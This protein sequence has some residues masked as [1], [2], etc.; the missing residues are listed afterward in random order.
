LN[1][2]ESAILAGL[3]QSPTYY[4][5]FIG[6]NDA[7]R[8]RAQDVL[9]RMREDGYITGDQEKA[10]LKQLGQIKFSSPKIS[11]LAPHFVFYVKDQIENEYG[12]KIIDQGVKIT[13]TISSDLQAMTEQIVKEEIAKLKGYNATNAAVI[14]LDSKTGEILSMVG[15]YDY[16]DEKFGKFNA[17]LGLR[18]PGSAMKP[19]NYALAFEK[20][21]TPASVIMDVKTTF[22][23]QGGQDYTPVNYDGKFRG[24][25]QIRFALGNSIN[26]PAVKSLA[27]VGLKDFLTKLNDLGMTTFAPTDANLKRFGLSLTLGGGETTLLNLTSAYSVLATGGIKHDISSIINISNF[28][29]KNIFKSV[30]S[31]EKQV[32]TPEVSF[33]ISHILSDN[34]ARADEFGL[35]SYLNIPGKTVS[36]KTGTTDDKHDNWTVGYTKSITV[37]VWVGNNDNSPMNPKIASG[38]TGASPIWYR[39]MREALKKYDDGIMNKPDKVKALTIDS[40]LG[41]LPKDGN[42][43]R[44]EYFIDGTQPTD[45][46]PF[47]K[48][49]KISK[50]NGKLANDVEIKTGNYDEKD[51][52]I[53]TES[54]PVSTDGKNR[55]QEAIDAWAGQQSDN[56]FKPPTETSDASADSVIVSIKSPSGQ[57]TVS[58]GNL[59]IKAKIIS[60]DKLKNV[61]IKL[62]GEVKFN[63]NED[64][65]DIDETISITQDGVYELQV[66]G[67]NEKDKQGESTIKFGVNKPWDYVVPTAIILPTA[68]PTPT[69]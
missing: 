55:W 59:N 19:F 23:N 36:V 43:T 26:V 3:P 64:K 9:R 56:K 68:T 58:S 54:D 44:A 28:N 7:W 65:K 30:R 15:S 52:I 8:G 69:H 31:G 17:A 18:Q 21:Y 34:N 1:L 29:G 57:T 5:P 6:K 45:I 46:S 66:I 12:S 38:I 20:G 62:N 39:I 50:S 4:S 49:L 47:Y 32:F 53:I 2:V 10:A 13:T 48:K 41:G 14:I 25:V 61:Q 24:P 42:Q 37:G 33:L 51:F 11:I 60:L 22:P 63:W 67:T 27:V 35:N 40:Y 16:N